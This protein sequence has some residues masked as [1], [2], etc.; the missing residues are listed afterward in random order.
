M[1]FLGV[2]PLELFF[3][4]IIA[5]IVLGP[6]DMV[7]AGRTIGSFL[8]RL[9]KSPTWQAVRQTST[10]LRYL[11][12]R[13]MREAG[14]EEEVEQ[15]KTIGQD[16]NKMGKVEDSLRQEIQKTSQEIKEAERDLSAWTTPPVS[17]ASADTTPE[18]AG[19]SEASQAETAETPTEPPTTDT[20]P[21]T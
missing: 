11:P 14:V 10:E 15:L 2:G 7:K 17:V 1:D 9:M 6:R 21:T 20:K 5:L 18:E 13:L 4:L 19:N 8:R 3:I 16:L 12:N